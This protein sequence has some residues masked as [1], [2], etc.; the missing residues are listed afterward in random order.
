[1]VALD[2]QG[3]ARVGPQPPAAVQN[4]LP[5][6]GTI[7]PP[8]A[9]APAA[10]RPIVVVTTEAASRAEP[11]VGPPGDEELSAAAM[12]Y[13]PAWLIS[14]VFHMSVLIILGL[15]AVKMRSEDRIRL[16][17]ETVYAEQLG[18]QL[19]FDSPL[20]MDDIEELDEPILS[21]SELPEVEDPFATPSDLVVQPDGLTATSDLEST[22]IGLALTGREEGSKRSLLGRYGGNAT[23]ERAVIDGLRWLAR[24]QR[25]D[26]SWSLAGPYNHG[27]G[28]SMDNPVAATAMALLA[29]QGN[30]N[31]HRKGK[32]RQ[33]VVRG[34]RWLLAEQDDD[35][36]F[37]HEGPLPHRFY[38]QGQ[39]TIAA[40]ELFAM[41][42]DEKY[43][44]P[45]QRA[46]QYC[47]ESQS[48]EGGW[49]YSPNGNSD[50]SVTGWIVMAL[51]SAR[52]AGLDVP[53]DHFRRVERF[54]D[55]V[56]RKDGS[57]YPYRRGGEV[58]LPMT[59]EA[60]L[61][62]QYLGWARD[63][64]RLVEGI[65]WIT[66]P[67]HLVDFD[68]GRNVYYWYY[69][70]QA[71][72][73]MGGEYWKRWNEVMRQ[74][75]PEQQIKAGRERGSWD[76]NRPTLDQWGPHGGRLYVT[77]LSIYMLEV[78]YRHLPIYGRVYNELLESGRS[79]GR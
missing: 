41:T 17:I 45:A 75:L 15:L 32:F 33:N 54:L 9:A 67:N 24:N 10:T 31:T 53:A 47:L 56:G 21:L 20:G 3:Q 77:C 2:P 72:H 36:S 25:K 27:V 79:E 69:A 37:F 7:G 68:R 29:F 23:T 42:K 14:V 58:T 60:L 19:E 26:G 11:S 63:D 8:Q 1:M 66:Q 64:P 16:D 52:M 18:D 50:V 70:T 39:C 74:A 4:S 49:R 35:G 71:V 34:W 76:P 12:R 62:R 43:K 30:G 78:Y 13:A 28:E 5:R 55:K 48:S 65:D 44:E 22:Q 38:T 61:C 57:R 40:C 46:V 59:A 73:H 51:Q 6:D